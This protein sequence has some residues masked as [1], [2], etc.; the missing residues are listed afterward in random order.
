MTSGPA[1]RP[2]GSCPYRRDVPSGVWAAEEYDKLPPYD[3]PTWAQPP[4]VF[5]CHQQ[6]GRL[7]AG[8]VGCHDMQE[9][10]GLRIAAANEH[11]D[12]DAV[13][14]ALDYV[15]PIAL[16]ESGAAAAAH[17]RAEVETPSTRARRTVEQ[18]KR[19]RQVTR[20]V[21]R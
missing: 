7:C 16:W 15:S 17:G 2:C 19:K 11:L 14:A 4:A 21:R 9:S 5:C 10:L 13:D 3:Q 18:L 8:W 1:A 6:D 12:P 20:G